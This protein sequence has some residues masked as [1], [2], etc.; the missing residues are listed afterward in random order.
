[1]VYLSV[2]HSYK[3]RQLD[4]KKRL[5]NSTIKLKNLKRK[6]NENGKRKIEI[7]KYIKTN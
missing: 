3:Y 7:L 6:K 1:M 5:Q 4:C 2:N